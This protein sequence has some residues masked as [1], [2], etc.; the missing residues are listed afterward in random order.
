MVRLTP[1]EQSGE[2]L[3]DPPFS[4]WAALARDHVAAA[5]S[6]RFT[7]AGVPATALRERARRDLGCA[8]APYVI[9]TGHQPDLWHCGIWAKT[10]LVDR[11]ARELDG[12]ATCLG[13]DSDAASSLVLRAPSRG[14]A[15]SV[16]ER[17]L[18]AA[19]QGTIWFAAPLPEAVA[20]ESACADVAA[21]LRGLPS[22]GPARQFD[23]WVAGLRAVFPAA[24]SIG[25]LMTRV[26]RHHERGLASRCTDVSLTVYSRGEAFLTFAA[27]I[28]LHSAA[29]VGAYNAALARYRQRAGLRNAAQPLPDLRR[30]GDAVE[31]P[32]WW[33]ADGR[34]QPLWARPVEDVV[35][36]LVDRRP[37]LVLP[38]NGTAAVRQMVEGASI[39]P[40]ALGLTLFHRLFCSDLFIHGTG[41]GRYDRVTDDLSLAYYGVAPPAFAVATMTL[42]LDAGVA[43]AAP[44]QLKQL[45]QTLDRF[46]RRPDRVATERGVPMPAAARRLADEADRVR[47]ALTASGGADG[48]GRSELRRLTNELRVALA[49]VETTL[50]AE[51]DEIRSRAAAGAVLRDRTYPICFFDPDVVRAHAWSA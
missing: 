28:A 29:F 26:R 31:L 41:G 38:A 1:P 34:R 11:L 7:V 25:D 14:A 44:E 35:Q 18:S 42:H 17:A 40:R 23:T 10:F 15:F 46:Q 37:L 50:H 20:I 2:V 48:S 13:V 39:A 27:D 3:C 49:D 24:T 33:I 12:V 51:L 5:T 6:Y 30:D 8:D 22:I 21:A 36:L 16:V 19:P 9:E 47:T 32:F 43:T 45:E 4:A